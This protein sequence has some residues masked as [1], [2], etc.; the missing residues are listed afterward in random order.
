MSDKEYYL[1]FVKDIKLHIM[2]IKR[3]EF[4]SNKKGTILGSFCFCIKVISR[5]RSPPFINFE[6]ENLKLIGGNKNGRK[7]KKKKI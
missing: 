4:S 6:F 3:A 5:C 1:I 2:I 7:T